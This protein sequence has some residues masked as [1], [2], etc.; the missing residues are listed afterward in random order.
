MVL[1]GTIL[2]KIEQAGTSVENLWGKEEALS[3][4]NISYGRKYLSYAVVQ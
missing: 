2:A 3:I 1:L 4:M